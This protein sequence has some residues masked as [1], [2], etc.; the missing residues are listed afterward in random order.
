MK[1]FRLLF[2]TGALLVMVYV[3]WQCS[4]PDSADAPVLPGA[5]QV[6]AK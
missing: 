3:L 5:T 6:P 4:Q 2:I 1:Y